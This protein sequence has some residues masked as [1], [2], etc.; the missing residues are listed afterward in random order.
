MSE[1][2][3]TLQLDSSLIKQFFTTIQT[4]QSDVAVLKS[5]ATGGS[6]SQPQFATL[7]QTDSAVSGKYPPMKRSIARSKEGENSEEEFLSSDEED[8]NVFTLTE[9]SSAFM[10]VALS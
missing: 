2:Q 5:G 4:L 6:R 10:E 1:E 3:S 8:D 7:S 9:V